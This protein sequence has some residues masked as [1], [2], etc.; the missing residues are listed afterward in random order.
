M[1]ILAHER[2]LYE[3]MRQDLEAKSLGKW[4]LIRDNDFVGVYDS[5]ETAAA[6]AV[7]RFGRGPYLI[8]EIGAP[9]MTLPAS[10]VYATMQN[11]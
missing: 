10:V 5:F 6:E 2:K 11:A 7:R 1:A 4:V 8:R 9:D 3:K